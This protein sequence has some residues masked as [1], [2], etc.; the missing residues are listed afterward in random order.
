MTSTYVNGIQ[1]GIEILYPINEDQ[2]STMMVFIMHLFATIFLPVYSVLLQK[3]GDLT[4]NLVFSILIFVGVVF[5]FLAPVKLNRQ[6]AETN[7]NVR[8]LKEFLPK[9]V[10]QI[11]ER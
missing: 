10:P 9:S 6:E 4:A 7:A 3:C 5:S 1:I 8:E 11:V 2:C